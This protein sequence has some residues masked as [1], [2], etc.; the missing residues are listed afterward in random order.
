MKDSTNKLAAL[1]LISAVIALANMGAGCA[2]TPKAQMAV[3]HKHNMTPA[4]RKLAQGWAPTTR[5]KTLSKGY[6]K[7]VAVIVQQDCFQ[8]GMTTVGIVVLDNEANGTIAA[9][10]AV[11]MITATLGY[12]PALATVAFGKDKGKV[13]MLNVVVPKES[14]TV[15]YRAE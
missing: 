10:D 2:V 7:H 11:G 3:H 14:G 4:A 13:F 6:S 5:C 12:K 9:K 8:R 15:A 1:L